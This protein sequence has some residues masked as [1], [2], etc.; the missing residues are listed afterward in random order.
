MHKGSAAHDRQV[1]HN[2]RQLR[3]WLRMWSQGA[4]LR[5]R[6]DWQTF[7]LAVEDVASIVLI[8]V[9]EGSDS[10]AQ[11]HRSPF[12][13]IRNEAE[14]RV[15]AV[16]TL[17]AA[18]ILELARRGGSAL[19]LVDLILRI[20]ALGE[21]VDTAEALQF[22]AEH[23]QGAFTRAESD[24]DVRGDRDDSL[25][26]EVL[27]T[28]ARGLRSLLVGKGGHRGSLQSFRGVSV[29]N[30]LD[31]EMTALLA[32]R[33]ADAIRAVRDVPLGEYGPTQVVSVVEL[34]PY[35]FVV[36]ALDSRQG[37]SFGAALGEV[38]TR[39]GTEDPARPP[40]SLIYLLVGRP[41]VYFMSA[42]L[43]CPDQPGASLTRTTLAELRTSGA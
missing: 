34:P 8:S 16:A 5:G 2:L 33:T 38:L 24:Q 42:L 14:R 40:I 11:I 1:E 43:T 12:D 37:A 35:R 15:A 4:R 23:H 29:F 7:D 26:R 22:L 9:V 13:S 19:D 17:P 39:L 10:R 20:S 36:G 21:P 25:Y 30:D 32:L 28:I 31:W 41:A 3:G 27:S 18:V 6:N